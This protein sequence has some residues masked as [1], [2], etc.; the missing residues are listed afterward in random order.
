MNEQ[1][2]VVYGINPVRELLI[3]NPG[4]VH[5]VVVKPESSLA[6]KVLELIEEARNLRVPVQR[7]PSPLFSRYPKAQGILAE[8]NMIPYHTEEELVSLI[9][10]LSLVVGL[11]GIEDP[12]NLGAILRTCHFFGIQAVLLPQKRTAPLSPAVFK[13]SAGALTHLQ[14]FRVKSLPG[15][16]KRFIEAGFT[17]AG[18]DSHRGVD[19]KEMAPGEKRVL[20]FGSEGQGLSSEPRRQCSE[21]YRIPS[22]TNFESLNLS[23]SVA[24]FLYG[25]PRAK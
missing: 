7:F 9:P 12:Q 14:P 13:S 15:A 5:R 17:I 2:S 16:L 20:L 21:F 23:V 19:L 3:S 1:E 10:K 8:L 22:P 11:D 18:T 4:R 24:L 6:P 25:A